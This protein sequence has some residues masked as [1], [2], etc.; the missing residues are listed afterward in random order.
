MTNQEKGQG[1]PGGEPGSNRDSKAVQNSRLCYDCGN[2]ILDEAMTAC[3]RCGGTDI[4]DRRCRPTRNEARGAP[5]L[6]PPFQ[7]LRLELGGTALISGDAGSGK[8]TIALAAGPTRYCTSEQEPEKVAQAWYR[9]RNDGKPPLISSCTSWDDLEEDLIG[10]EEGELVVVDSVSQLAMPEETRRIVAKVIG[11]IR[12]ARA[13]GIFICQFTKSGEMLGPNELRHL[14]DAVGDIPNDPTGLRR[15][16]FSKN[17]YGSLSATYFRLGSEGVSVETFPYAYSVEGSAGKYR[18]HLYPSS[19]AKLSGILET[20]D[21]AG[22]ALEGMASAAIACRGYRHGFATTPD[23]GE[24]QA[25]AER[26]GLRW[27]TP[28]IAREL[29][30]EAGI[31]LDRLKKKS[32][33]KHELEI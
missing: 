6:P 2:P 32:Q 11:K 15:L 3:D 30:E 26:H 27:V 10:L 14:V 33:P 13:R 31:D 5:P 29:L 25:F 17:R 20:L 28:Q 19:G 9:V 22:L 16:G 7:D 1:R 23:N 12:K 24:R 18:L 21:D 4:D 8:T